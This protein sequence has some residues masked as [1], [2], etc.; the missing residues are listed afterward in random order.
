MKQTI[1][2]C[3]GL[4]LA[5]VSAFLRVE[6]LKFLNAYFI[7]ISLKN[8]HTFAIHSSSNSL[9]VLNTYEQIVTSVKSGLPDCHWVIGEGSNTVFTSDFDGAVFQIAS[10][11]I[12]FRETSSEYFLDIQAGHSWHQLVRWAVQQNIGGLENLALIPGTVGAAP[13]QNIGAYG[14]ELKEFV[15]FVEYVDKCS[16]EIVRLS[17]EECQFGYRDSIFKQSLKDRVVITK[18]GIRLNK[19][20]KPQ[21]GYKGLEHLDESSTPSMIFEAVVKLRKEKLPDPQSL[22]NAGSFFK[23]PVL[24]EER[25]TELRGNYPH[26]PVYSHDSA[27]KVP[28]GWLI[29]QCNLKGFAVGGAAVHKN[30]ALVLTNTGRASGCELL[31]LAHQVQEKVFEKFSIELQAEVR[32]VGKNGEIFL[33]G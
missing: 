33:S 27:F 14:K 25:I 5:W 1:F 11:G 7:L 2:A 20:W 17:K 21:L 22:G 30:H 9:D 23:N 16:G 8:L 4:V 24:C 12:N 13:I 28:A 29:D 26:M 18:V 31:S 19:D 6:W 15:H 10:S 3:V 32:L